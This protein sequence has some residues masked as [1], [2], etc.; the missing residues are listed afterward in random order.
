MIP[1]SESIQALPEK[2][3]LIPE[4][5]FDC[6]TE[7][8]EKNKS[9]PGSKSILLAKLL[10]LIFFV[11]FGII[12]FIVF[13]LFYFNNPDGVDECWARNDFYVPIQPLDEE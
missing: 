3:L 6:T 10:I 8:E 4:T 9:L 7:E 1:F 12:W 13:G 5:I 11:I 2:T